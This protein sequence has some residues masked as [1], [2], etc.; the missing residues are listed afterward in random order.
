MGGVF[1]CVYKQHFLHNSVIKLFQLLHQTEVGGYREKI[2]KK[3]SS[4]KAAKF[5]SGD[6]QTLV[7]FQ[8]SSLR[9]EVFLATPIWRALNLRAI[10]HGILG[11]ATF[12]TPAWAD[13]EHLVLLLEWRKKPQPNTNICRGSWN[14]EEYSEAWLLF[15]NTLLTLER[16][17]TAG[18]LLWRGSGHVTS[19]EIK[20]T[21]PHACTHEECAPRVCGTRSTLPQGYSY[22][23]WFP[24]PLSPDFLNQPGCHI[25]LKNKSYRATLNS[26]R[27][28][29]VTYHVCSSAIE[30]LRCTAHCLRTVKQSERQWE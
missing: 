13:R 14:S 15:R 1:M 16:S 12:T 17:G 21:S 7:P 26:H 10:L 24:T 27:W 4:G 2:N 22:K 28:S 6:H 8:A 19:G 5:Q 30:R 3:K 29:S 25:W 23:S 18:A 11:K 9:G 20:T